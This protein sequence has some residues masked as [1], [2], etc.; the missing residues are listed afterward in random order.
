MQLTVVN[1]NEAQM[2]EAIRAARDGDFDAAVQHINEAQETI[3][4]VVSIAFFIM[5]TQHLMH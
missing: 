2:L 1:S 5:F 3:N 4:E